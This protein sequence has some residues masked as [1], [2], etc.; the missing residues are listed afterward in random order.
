MKCFGPPEPFGQARHLQP[1]RQT[2]CRRQ[3]FRRGRFSPVGNGFHRRSKSPHS[4]D[5]GPLRNEASVPRAVARCGPLTTAAAAGHS[6][7]RRNG[8]P[9]HA[10]LGAPLGRPQLGRLRQATSIA[11]FTDFLPRGVRISPT[12]YPTRRSLPTADHR[13]NHA[14]HER[15]RVKQMTA[16]SLQDVMNR[17]LVPLAVL[18]LSTASKP[19]TAAGRSFSP[20]A[21]WPTGRNLAHLKTVRPTTRLASAWELQFLQAVDISVSRYTN[22]GAGTQSWLVPKH[23]C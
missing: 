22:T 16:S 13:Q 3:C 2:L 1:A 5:F 15:R 19:R 12:F 17:I 6:L 14:G 9:V 18:L 10:Y 21:S 4:G 11:C 7:A 8:H 20:P 23:L